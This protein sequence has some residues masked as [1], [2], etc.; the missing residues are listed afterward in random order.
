M[1]L[2]IRNIKSK[3]DMKLF[4]ELAKRLGLKT[5]KLSLEEM[6]DIALGKAMEEGKKSGLVSEEAVMKTLHKVQRRK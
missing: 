6:E 2:V 3:Q 1:E 5:A 4:A